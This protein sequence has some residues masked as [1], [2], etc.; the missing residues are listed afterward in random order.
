MVELP[1]AFLLQELNISILDKPRRE[2]TLADFLS[3][4]HNESESITV[5]DSFL[6]EHLFAISTKT[7]WFAIFLIIWLQVNYLNIY[8][9]KKST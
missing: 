5:D 8:L 1:G 9:Q 3:R 7:P 4:I 2:D 6:D